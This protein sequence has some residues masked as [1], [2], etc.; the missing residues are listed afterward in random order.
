LWSGTIA[1]EIAEVLLPKKEIESKYP[2]EPESVQ[3]KS[4]LNDLV[5]YYRTPKGILIRIIEK[6]GTL[7]YQYDNNNLLK[8]IRKRDNFFSFEVIQG[9]NLAFTFNGN[10]PNNFT[11][12]QESSPPRI[13]L[14]SS[15]QLPSEF[16]LEAYVGTYHN[17]ELDITFDVTLDDGK[18]MALQNGRTRA[19]ELKA[20]TKK[21]L[22]LSNY[23]IDV[24][25]DP[26][27]RVKTLL[28]TSNRIQ[29][30]RFVK[31]EDMQFQPKIPTK[32]G[33]I[34]V[35]TIGNI[36]GTSSQI[37]LTKN[38]ENGNEIWSK[39]FGGKSYDKANSIIQTSDGGYLIV[40]ATSSFGNGN[41]DSYV[42]KVDGK[43]KEQWSNTYGD[44]YNEY[45]Y[46]AEETDTGYL[47]KGAKQEC[48]SNT[49]VFNRTCTN[50]VWLI[51]IDK[52]GK[53]V[54]NELREEL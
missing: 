45:A 15:D 5:G 24:E 21:D 25:R 36:D 19:K 34:N 4:D 20:F 39:Q 6:D 9:S 48:S 47:I 17:E 7:Y 2:T 18:L 30:V 42:I 8:L 32:N 51:Y 40:G 13:H 22:L 14:R 53:E 27:D 43:G 52:N 28:F 49:D 12:Y 10:Q 37:L 46:T 35:S 50:K 54:S 11:L 29:K 1:D 16:E 33:S 38:Y 31:K 26:F 3:A 41:Y 44:F 23:R